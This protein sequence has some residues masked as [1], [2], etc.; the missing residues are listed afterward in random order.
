[1]S[2]IEQSIELHSTHNGSNKVY[3]VQLCKVDDGF[4]VNYQNGRLGSTLA[5]GTKTKSPVALDRAQAIYDRLVKEKINGESRYSVVGAGST[6]AAQI[7][8]DKTLSGFLPMLSTSIDEARVDE[9]LR[10]D[11]YIL[12][13]KYDG[14]RV[15]IVV[16]ASGAVLG[17]NRR[18]IVRPLPL[19]LVRGLQDAQI[20][21]KTVLDGELVGDS[22]WCFDLL[23]FNGQDCTPL[24]YAGRREHMGAA[25]R[26]CFSPHIGRVSNSYFLSKAEVFRYLKLANAEGV[27]FRDRRAPYTVGRSESCL[28]YK[29]KESATLLVDGFET[30]KRSI[31]LGGL[32]DNGVRVTMGKVTIP[33]NHPMP[34]I[35]SI[36]EVEYLYASPETH[37]L[38]QPVYKG[39]RGDQT[40]TACL[41]AQL[42]YKASSEIAEFE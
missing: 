24:P 41:L 8:T 25:L 3:H 30:D 32:D 10:D 29:F 7:V 19:V 11:N 16:T 33:P 14:E 18:G 27:I 20:P 5:S 28:K 13:Q 12:Q 26:N 15:Q 42:K 36:V 35:D 21:P 6:S 4:V 38:Q 1:M 34:T 22:Y 31:F 39:V 2:S 9:L 40:T 17:S 23:Q 37:A